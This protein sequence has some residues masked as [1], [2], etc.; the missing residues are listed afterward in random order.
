MLYIYINGKTHLQ[1]S[2]GKLPNV[3]IV[4]YKEMLKKQAFFK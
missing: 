2:V 1:M 4:K 3:R